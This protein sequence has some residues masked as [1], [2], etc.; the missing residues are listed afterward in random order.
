MPLTAYLRRYWL[1]S[2]IFPKILLISWCRKLIKSKFFIFPDSWIVPIVN[3]F[4]FDAPKFATG[5]FNYLNLCMAKQSALWS[6]QKILDAELHSTAKGKAPPQ[7]RAIG[8]ST[9]AALN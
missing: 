2:Y 8:V 4:L 5:H 7:K 1:A 6:S 9:C 3:G